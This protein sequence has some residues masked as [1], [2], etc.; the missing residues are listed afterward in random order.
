M[1]VFQ[2]FITATIYIIVIVL[3]WRYWDA[4]KRFLFPERK[5]VDDKKVRICPK[6]GS[7]NVQSV[8]LVSPQ[9]S[10]KVQGKLFVQGY[11]APENPEVYMCKSCNY[12]GICSEIEI[13]QVKGYRRE[14]KEHDALKNFKE[15]E[16][17]EIIETDKEWIFNSTTFKGVFLVSLAGVFV[18][19]FILYLTNAGKG[20]QVLVWIFAVILI[21]QMLMINYFRVWKRRIFKKDIT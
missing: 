10:G 19:P 5:H 21:I 20:Y 2:G 13:D 9:E 18:A 3:I 16:K 15:T 4:M 6:C 8:Y 12:Y 17:R 11:N 7:I 1:E 14:L